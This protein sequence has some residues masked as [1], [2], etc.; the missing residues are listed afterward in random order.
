MNASEAWLKSKLR[1]IIAL[2]YDRVD[3]SFN[4]E[5]WEITGLTRGDVQALAWGRHLSLALQKAIDGGTY[6]R[7]LAVEI[8]DGE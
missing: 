6:V 2:G 4:G 3:V 1:Q 7:S 8:K 5:L